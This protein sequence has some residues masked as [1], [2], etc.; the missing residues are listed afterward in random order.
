MKIHNKDSNI[1]HHHHK[2]CYISAIFIHTLSLAFTVLITD[3]G[4]STNCKC[5]AATARS[6]LAEGFTKTW[7]FKKP[8]PAVLGVILGLMWIFWTSTASARCSQ[9]NLVRL[10]SREACLQDLRSLLLL[11]SPTALYPKV[12]RR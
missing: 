11:A 3:L 4:I 6:V 1:I 7:L 12:T 9:I 2:L 8:N 5:P 10:E